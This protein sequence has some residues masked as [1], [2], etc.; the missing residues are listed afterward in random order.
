MVFSST[1]PQKI[2][3]TSLVYINE[4][5][6]VMREHPREE[7]KVVSQAIFSEEIRVEKVVDDWSY[8]TSSDGYSGWVQSMHFIK[9]EGPYNTS[10]KVCRLAAHIYGVEDTEFGPIKTLPYGAKLRVV[11]T[12][13]PRWIKIAMPDGKECF[14]QRGDVTP[15]LK[16]D[17]KK[18]LVEFSKQFL[19]LPYTWGG[20]SS[21]GYD[22]SG[23]VQML[24][25]QINV[26]LQ[27]DARQQVLDPRFQTIALDKLEPGDLIFFGKSAEKILHV[28]MFIGNGQLIQATVRELRPWLRISNLSDLEWSGHRDAFY[29]YRIARQLRDV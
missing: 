29:P 26:N 12:T 2:A 14:I 15:E 3:T 27:R 21:F 6:A 25:N 23:F 10:L 22:C 24:Y 9:L 16:V 1:F 8:I 11:D 17:T 20:R 28:G 4:P 7:S 18:D 13:D 5:V 19:G